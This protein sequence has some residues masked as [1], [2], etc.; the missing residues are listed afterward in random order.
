MG[1]RFESSKSRLLWLDQFRPAY[2]PCQKIANTCPERAHQE[3]P[4]KNKQN[5]NHLGLTDC[6]TNTE[7]PRHIDIHFNNCFNQVPQ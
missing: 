1:H 5:I 7:F 6:N 3:E 4:C 2:S